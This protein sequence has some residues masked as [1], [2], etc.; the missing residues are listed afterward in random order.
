[1]SNVRYKISDGR[2]SAEYDDGT[3][4]DFGV[5]TEPFKSVMGRRPDGELM[6]CTMTD[7]HW[8]QIQS[9]CFVSSDK[10]ST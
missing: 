4:A 6:V 5:A 2:I 7:E 10:P 3:V 9:A 1:M 8:E